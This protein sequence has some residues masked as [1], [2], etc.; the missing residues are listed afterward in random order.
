M[1][2]IEFHKK[3]FNK[4]MVWC[5]AFDVT[6]KL[7]H[8]VSPTIYSVEIHMNSNH[9]RSFEWRSSRIRL[10]ARAYA[11][12]SFV[13]YCS[14]PE[15]RWASE[16]SWAKFLPELETLCDFSKYLKDVQ[17]LAEVAR[18]HKPAAIFG[19]WGLQVTVIKLTFRHPGRPGDC[20][21]INNINNN[22][23]ISWNWRTQQDNPSAMARE[24]QHG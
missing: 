7:N 23:S 20:Q 3:G 1:R 6:T 5:A 9:L 11:T 2:E 13:G 17:H 4:A 18:Q 8:D 19:W 21:I 10:A 14:T 12:N 16:L 22:I 24:R 15:G